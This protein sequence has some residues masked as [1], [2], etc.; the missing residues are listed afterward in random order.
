MFMWAIQTS[1]YESELSSVKSAP[2]EPL[3]VGVA[4]ESKEAPSSAS[5][6]LDTPTAST[7]SVEEGRSCDQLTSSK[8]WVEVQRRKKAACG[9]EVK[10]QCMT[11]K[12]V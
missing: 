5:G 9:G 8:D 11:D 2:S 4:S 1:G 12:M 3:T 10:V 6:I 7:V